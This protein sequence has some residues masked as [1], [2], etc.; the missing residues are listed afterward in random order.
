[1]TRGLSLV[2]VQGEKKVDKV[3][4]LFVKLLGAVKAHNIVPYAAFKPC[5]LF[6]LGDIK[7]VWQA[8]YIENK[9][10]LTAVSVLEAEGQG[11]CRRCLWC[12]RKP[13]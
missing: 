12:S 5:V 9:V 6:K 2:A 3:F 10:S 1:M 4:E 7:G 13:P 11:S 8:S